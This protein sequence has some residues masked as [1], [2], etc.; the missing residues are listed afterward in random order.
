MPKDFVKRLDLIC[1]RKQFPKLLT[2]EQKNQNKTQQPRN[3]APGF[4]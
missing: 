4:W 1:C 3:R 2:F